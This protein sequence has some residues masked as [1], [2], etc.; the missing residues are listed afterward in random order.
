VDRPPKKGQ[1]PWQN[2]SS[3][4]SKV[5]RERVQGN[6]SEGPPRT[7]LKGIGRFWKWEGS[8]KPVNKFKHQTRA[9]SRYSK[10]Y[11]IIINLNKG[12][13]QENTYLHALSKES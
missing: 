13:K 4:V 11:I 10:R 8:Q 12:N 7:I 3:F 5:L 2:L 9:L 6:V 1:E